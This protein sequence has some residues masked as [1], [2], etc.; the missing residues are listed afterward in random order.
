MYLLQDIGSIKIKFY[1]RFL[2]KISKTLLIYYRIE[3]K[4]TLKDSNRYNDNIA[5][6]AL[7]GSHEAFNII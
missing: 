1:H 7:P 6:N 2:V 3:K 5:N 4:K